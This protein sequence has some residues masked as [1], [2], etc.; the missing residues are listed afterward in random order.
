MSNPER[1]L[2]KNCIS[3]FIIRIDIDPV[4]NVDFIGLFETLK[5]YYNR[6]AIEVATNYNLNLQ[7][8][9]TETRKYNKYHL[10][11]NDG[12]HVEIDSLLKVIIFNASKYVNNDVYKDR[13]S[14]IISFLIVNNS[15]QSRRIG[16]RYIN[17][18]YCPSQSDISKILP[19]TEARYIKSSLRNP[20][21]SRSLA[22]L[23][24]NKESHYIRVQ[25]GIPNRFYP[26]KITR[27][28]LM[29]DIDVYSESPINVNE[30]NETIDS[31]N[32]I[33]YDTFVSFVKP[34]FLDSLR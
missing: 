25:Y 1:T 24:H 27:M 5:P 15:L 29:I 6:T 7:S 32:H 18:F 26:S 8:G 23:E 10:Y 13:M 11:T 2:Y 28:D 3:Q 16:M 9:E 12:I 21:I 33:S 17:M 14:T 20:D 34:S 22:I 19:D 31:F 4:A 30:W